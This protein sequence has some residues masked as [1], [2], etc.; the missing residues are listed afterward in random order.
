MAAESTRAARPSSGGRALAVVCVVAVAAVGSVT[1]PFGWAATVLVLAISAIALVWALRSPN[2]VEPRDP[3][4][5]RGTAVWSALLLA[6]AGWEAYAFV[7]QPDWTKPSDQ[8]P[9]LSTLLDPGLEQ[10]PLR[11][12]GW[13]VWLAVGCWLVTR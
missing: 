4:L 3:S 8:H 12:A 10:G 9:T 2:S 1:R 13:L 7:R 5:R 11:F 6:I